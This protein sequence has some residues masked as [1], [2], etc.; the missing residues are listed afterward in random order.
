M[1]TVVEDEES[2]GGSTSARDGA[3]ADARGMWCGKKN[4]SRLLL[5]HALFCAFCSSAWPRSLA[6]R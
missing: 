1:G 5:F 6:M 4:T 3:A 2:K